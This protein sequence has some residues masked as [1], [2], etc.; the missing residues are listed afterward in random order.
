MIIDPG[1]FDPKKFLLNEID[2]IYIYYKNNLEILNKISYCIDSENNL[3]FNDLISR[4]KK[5]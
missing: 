4:I 5:I 2:N 3:P 1:V